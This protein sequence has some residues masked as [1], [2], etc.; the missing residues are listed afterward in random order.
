[1]I[2]FGYDSRMKDRWLL[3]TAIGF[4]VLFVLSLLLALHEGGV[5]GPRFL[6]LWA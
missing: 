5:F 1:M 2:A 6:Q 3:W 4:F